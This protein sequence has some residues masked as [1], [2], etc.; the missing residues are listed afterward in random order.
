MSPTMNWIVETKR[1]SL[2]GIEHNHF[3]KRSKL[4]CGT[5]HTS[6]HIVPWDELSPHSLR[7]PLSSSVRPEK[8]VVRLCPHPLL[9]YMLR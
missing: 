4:R 3:R 2:A 9:L 6:S 8:A 5:V 1:S 7:H